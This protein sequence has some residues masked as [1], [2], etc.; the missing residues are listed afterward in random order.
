MGLYNTVD[1]THK[2]L[3]I[4]FGEI[5][6]C[7]LNLH[8]KSEKE[9]AELFNTNIED[10]L[11]EQ[12]ILGKQS[13]INEIN[14]YKQQIES[15]QDLFIKK[16]QKIEELYNKLEKSFTN[17]LNQGRI[18][19]DQL[20]NEKYNEVERLNKIINSIKPTE[21]INS[22]QKGD[23]FENIINNNFVKNID[24]KCYILDTSD[25]RGSGDRIINCDKF[26]IMIECKNKMVIQ[27]SDIEQFQNH[28]TEDFHNNKYDIALFISYSCE[29]ILGKGSFKIE[30]YEQKLVG[31]F[32][33]SNELSLNKKN[34]LVL[35]FLKLIYDHHN[36]KTITENEINIESIL[37]NQILELHD[38]IL[39]LEKYEI[40]YAKTIQEKYTHK[41]ILLNNLLNKFDEINIPIPFELQ[42]ISGTDDMFI[43]R[44]VKMLNSEFIIPKLN[45][46]KT[47]I[48]ELNLSQF[49][50]KFL[51]KKGITRDKFTDKFNQ[52]YQKNNII[53]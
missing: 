23:S 16:N 2:K 5:I 21:Y 44:I 41:K 48:D 8:I 19:N 29:H 11:K 10:K 40:P 49:Y 1:E 12:Y 15:N 27:K 17:G 28:Y 50:Q 9:I 25:I 39:K 20:L 53:Y 42:S 47:L 38:D 36:N 24:R 22:K 34:E 37:K 51:N 4:Q 45:W 3:I 30:Q 7:K 35:Y 32:G 26:K 13:N 14:Y 46:K 52:L 18:F 33:I 43:E 6:Y 31:Y